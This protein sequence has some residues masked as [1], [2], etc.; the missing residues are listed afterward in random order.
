ME[1]V[2]SNKFLTVSAG[3]VEKG[4]LGGGALKL[5]IMF[6][7]SRTIDFNDRFEKNRNARWWNLGQL[8]KTLNNVG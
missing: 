4:V 2:S 5:K 7:G 8:L 6:G 1:L 3:H